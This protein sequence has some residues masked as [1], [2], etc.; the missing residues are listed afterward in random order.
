[1]DPGASPILGGLI[2]WVNGQAQTISLSI[3]NSYS[4]NYLKSIT[5]NYTSIGQTVGQIQAG[6][7]SYYFTNTY[8]DDTY[9][10][11][12]P[13]IGYK[14]IA[15]IASVDSTVLSCGALYNT[16]RATTGFSGNNINCG[17]LHLK[18]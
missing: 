12:L 3:T 1:T 14:F 16:I 10:S 11:T 18:V 15:P 6:A 17:N 2:G 8:A 4:S 5:G 9:N 13:V 7:F